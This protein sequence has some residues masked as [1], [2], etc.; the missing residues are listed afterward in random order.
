MSELQ[1][2][3]GQEIQDERVQEQ[4]AQKLV[5][6]GQSEVVVVSLGAAGALLASQ[7]GFE[8]LRTLSVQVK[9]DV[10]AGDSMIAGIVLKLAQGESLRKA[11][12]FGIAAGAAAVMT[13]GTELCRREDTELLYDKMIQ[14]G[15]ESTQIEVP[16]FSDVPNIRR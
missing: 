8:R 12:C 13:P 16:D 2:L 10:G 3:V 15:F 5:E 1:E 4:S 11:V 9:S 6:S 14:E 7:R